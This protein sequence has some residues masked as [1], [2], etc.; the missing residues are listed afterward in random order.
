MYEKYQTDLSW[1]YVQKITGELNKPVTVI[2]G[3]AVYFL[4]KDKFK[5]IYGKDYLGS[6][7]LDLGYELKGDLKKSNLY[8]DIEY[9]KKQG[10]RI[11]GFRLMQEFH[12]E[13][14]KKLGLEEAKKIPSHFIQHI[15]IDLIVNH[16]PKGFKNIFGF[17]PIDEPLLD[18]VYGGR[19]VKVSNF[20]IPTPEVI[21]AMKLNSVLGRDKEHKR[22]KDVC[23]IFALLYCSNIKINEFYKIY[24]KNK[25]KKILR[26]LDVEDASNLLNIDKKI[27]KRIFDEV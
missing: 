3:W 25:A 16:I 4:V 21:L 24:N 23:D 12:T 19:N 26:D 9:L 13:T 2:G 11:L 17:N 14:K 1:K 6:K 27:I 20:V 8:K 22:V 5:E 15:Y 18:L 10:F 7:D